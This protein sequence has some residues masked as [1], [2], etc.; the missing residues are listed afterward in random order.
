MDKISV[1]VP[2]Y[3]V[4]TCVSQCIESI[5]NQDYLD[6]ELILIDDGSTDNSGTICDCYQKKDVRIKVIHQKNQGLSGARNT[7]MDNCTGDYLTFIDSDDA[8]AKNYLSL[9][10]NALTESNADVSASLS[11]DVENWD[12]STEFPIIKEQA[13]RIVYDG[14]S[15]CIRLYSGDDRVTIGSTSKLYKRNIVESLRFPL[16]KSHEDQYFTPIAF[17]NANKIVFVKAHNYFYRVRNDSITH[18]N[19]SIKR[20]DDVWAI[21][22]CIDYFTQHNEPEIVEA[23]KA[24]KER[25]IC[26]YS[27]YAKHDNVKIPKQ[28]RRNLVSALYKLR[29]SSPD[30]YEYYLSRVSSK[31][32]IIYEYFIKIKKTVSGK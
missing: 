19:F 18:K 24:K 32:P 8:I 6:F 23:A 30:K 26:L 9:L 4:E 17:Y 11:E 12:D 10:Y 31:L 20:Y 13:E 3:N 22:Q 14:K 7:G 15:A 1:I 29:N 2:V 25:L 28:Y 16:R 21:N 27:L 5:L